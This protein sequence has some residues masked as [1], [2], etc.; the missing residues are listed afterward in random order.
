MC[1]RDRSGS[2]VKA[3]LVK[4]D[5][6]KIT[7]NRAKDNFTMVLKI[8]DLSQEDREFVSRLKWDGEKSIT[9]PIES[10]SPEDQQMVRIA[11]GEVRARK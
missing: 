9:V 2:T 4:R 8:K 10:L 1:I 7:L 5:K 6:K 11:N 3:S